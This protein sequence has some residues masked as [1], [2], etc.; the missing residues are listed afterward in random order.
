ML[1]L[2]LLLILISS[3]RIIILIDIPIIPD[4]IPIIKYMNLIFLWFVEYVHLLI[5]FNIKNINFNL[6]LKFN[7]FFL[8][9]EKFNF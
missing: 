1:L 4:Q 2:K 3:V 9:I 7:F 6:N 5:N 8:I